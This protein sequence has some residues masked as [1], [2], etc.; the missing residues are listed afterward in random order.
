MEGAIIEMDLA[1][2]S[3]R[4]IEDTTQTLLGT[5]LAPETISNLNKNTMSILNLGILARCPVHI[6]PFM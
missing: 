2:V 6:Y 4:W 1:G 3:V 5:K